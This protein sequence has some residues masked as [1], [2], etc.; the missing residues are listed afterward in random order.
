MITDSRVVLVTGASSGLGKSTAELLSAQGIR[1]F[2]TSRKTRGEKIGD[3]EMIELDVTKGESVD[4]CI[5][6]VI[7]RAGRIDV[8]VNNAG[9][10]LVGALEETL[11]DEAKVLF[12]TNFFGAVRM[13]D[14][15]LPYM[16]KQ[17]RG[18]IINVASVA[19]FIPTPGRGF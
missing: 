3:F 10:S 18:R 9:Q 15:V 6:T 14:A 4:N 17:S 7:E 5:R 16:K 8:L 12:E 1:V 2:G 19:A 11:V 13:V